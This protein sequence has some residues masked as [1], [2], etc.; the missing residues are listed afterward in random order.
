[1]HGVCFWPGH[2]P[3]PILLGFKSDKP[4]VVLY[5]IMYL[6]GNAIGSSVICGPVTKILVPRTYF[7]S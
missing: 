4:E 3:V 5:V 1:M 6:P 2:R 7:G